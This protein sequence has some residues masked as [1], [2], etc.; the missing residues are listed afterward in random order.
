VYIIF[1][2][3]FCAIEKDVNIRINWT[4]QEIEKKKKRLICKL[5]VS[6]FYSNSKIDM[7]SF[8]FLF[9]FDLHE[10]KREG[11]KKS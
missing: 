4:I 3:N 9:F 11:R 7:W 1:L 2:K 5:Y 6:S 10:T 8:F